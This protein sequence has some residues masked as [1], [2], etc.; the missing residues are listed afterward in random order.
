MTERPPTDDELAGLAEFIDVE[1][2]QKIRTV[3]RR[4]LDP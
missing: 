1:T 2:I 4:G 3:T